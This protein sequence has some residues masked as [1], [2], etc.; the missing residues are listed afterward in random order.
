MITEITSQ[1][2]PSVVKLLKQEAIFNKK[3]VDW[4][5]GMINRLEGG[6]N[7]G[8]KG[9]ISITD[10]KPD[11]FLVFNPQSG[12]IPFI[13]I[14]QA[15]EN[16]VDKLRNLISH[17]IVNSKI[18]LSLSD[19]YGDDMKSMLI[20]EFNFNIHERIEMKIQNSDIKKFEIKDLGSKFEI[21]SWNDNMMIEISSLMVKVTGNSIDGELFR[22]FKSQNGCIDYIKSALDGEFKS[23]NELNSKV[24][25]DKITNEIIG[26]CFVTKEDETDYSIPIMGVSTK[27]R[28]K[29]IGKF[30]IQKTLK[31]IVKVAN[32]VEFVHL[33]VTKENI[34]AYPL[35]KKLGFVEYESQDI[36]QRSEDIE[37]K[38]SNY[39]G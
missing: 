11:G 21:T 8:M 24:L 23:E 9:R 35:Y 26:Y 17:L 13:L 32:S 39:G 7:S 16:R 27:Y 20:N 6:L 30:L 34:P 29:G 2:L 28:G 37:S 18:P 1:N 38:I 33:S 3:D 14:S 36:L 10:D 5:A 12:L 31:E 22:Q 19:S 4:T 25:I 15:S